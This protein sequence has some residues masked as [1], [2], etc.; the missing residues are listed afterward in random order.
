MRIDAA[1][2]FVDRARFRY[3]WLAGA[4][5][6]MQRDFTPA[7]LETILARNRFEGCVAVPLLDDPTEV[8]WL[9][10]IAAA[11]SLVRGV[12]GTATPTNWERWQR[13]PAFCGVLIAA[14][15]DAA[16]EAVR[17]GLCIE[18]ANL[19][20]ALL[21][22]ESFPE[23][24]LA[25]AHLGRPSWRAED[26]NSWRE[27][28]DRLAGAPNVYVKVS[29]LLVDSSPV[30]RRAA[31]CR[32]WIQHLI[33]VFGPDRLMYGSD[34]PRCMYF[35]TWK[36]HLAA[37]TQAMGPQTERFRDQILGETALAFYG[38][39]ARVHPSRH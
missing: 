21:F 2:G 29:G 18:T 7:Q 15:L 26:F 20:S 22:A 27:A 4:P 11:H 32:P 34:W 23:A 16:R 5:A 19:A 36:E 24:R 35:G 3:P 33:S 1:A 8:D 30:L 9:L 14:E 6:H 31:V 38:L 28:V 39:S 12:V 37:F 10:T 13:Q 17:R 25:L